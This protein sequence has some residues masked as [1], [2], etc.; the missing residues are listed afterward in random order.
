M[1]KMANKKEI[2]KWVKLQINKEHMVKLPNL[3]TND[4]MLECKT[5]IKDELIAEMVSRFIDY[6]YNSGYGCRR[7]EF[8]LNIETTS[9]LLGP[10]KMIMENIRKK[11]EAI[12]NS[13]KEIAEYNESLRMKLDQFKEDMLLIGNRELSDYAKTF[14]EKLKK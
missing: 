14:M 8:T 7:F 6:R 12:L 4:V 13:N 5:Y 2:I 10:I 1:N 3:S 9:E 11:E